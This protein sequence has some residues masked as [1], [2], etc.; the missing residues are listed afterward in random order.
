MAYFINSSVEE[1][2]H[3]ILKLQ[4]PCLN[5]TQAE[6]E[7]NYEGDRAVIKVSSDIDRVILLLFIIMNR[8]VFLTMEVVSY[9]S[10]LMTRKYV[11]IFY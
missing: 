2:N 7:W 5:C 4:R 8:L 10:Y 1:G 11:L 6:C 9:I 3:F